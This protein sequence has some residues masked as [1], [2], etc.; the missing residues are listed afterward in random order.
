MKVTFNQLNL[1]TYSKKHT[2]IHLNF[3][4]IDL[5]HVK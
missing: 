1:I 4:K 2:K 5:I 3:I